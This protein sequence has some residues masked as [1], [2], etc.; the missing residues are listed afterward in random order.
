MEAVITKTETKTYS[1]SRNP[2][3]ALACSLTAFKGEYFC[4]SA[5]LLT[6]SLIVCRWLSR[7]H[8]AHVIDV[9]H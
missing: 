1:P 6:A 5:A 8:F 2:S 4:F 7:L 9:N 3:I